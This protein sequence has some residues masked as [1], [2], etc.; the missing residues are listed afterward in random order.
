MTVYQPGTFFKTKAFNLI[1]NDYNYEVYHSE[2]GQLF[3]PLNNFSNCHFDILAI[4][5]K[6]KSD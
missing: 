5:V 1:R 3:T 6:T 4:A 2:E